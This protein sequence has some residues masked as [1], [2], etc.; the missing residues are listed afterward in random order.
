MAANRTIRNHPRMTPANF[1][2]SCSS[3]Y[4]GFFNR[5]SEIDWYSQILGKG[6]KPRIHVFTGPPNSG[7]T[8][9]LNKVLNIEQSA[10]SNSPVVAIDMREIPFTDAPSFLNAMEEFLAPWYNRVKEMATNFSVKVGNDLGNVTFVPGKLYEPDMSVPQK[11]KCIFSF[12]VKNMPK[13]SFWTGEQCPILFIDEANK[14]SMLTRTKEGRDALEQLLEFFVK[15]T[16]QDSLF[17]VVLASSDSF[18]HLWLANLIGE[19]RFTTHVIGHL[20]KEEARNYWEQHA[21]LEYKKI[22]DKFEGPEFEDV[23]AICGGSF[24]LMDMY[25]EQYDI[26][27]GSVLP[28]DF[29]FV[30]QQMRRL[31][32]YGLLES[33]TK[34]TKKDFFTV[35]TR[36]SENGFVVYDDLCDEMTKVVVDALIKT[37]LLH[38]R[39]THEFVYDLEYK[40]KE[41]ILTPTS[42]SS[43]AAMK[44]IVKNKKHLIE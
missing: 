30:K 18:Y 2:R 44:L 10:D 27:G 23:F 4:T 13:H 29:S 22:K 7:K 9:L 37:N 25:C 40:G 1:A 12:I 39:P 15:C 17:P 32:S 8:A 11:L 3:S 36:M 28:M 19:D 41:S 35:M 16:K 38:L 33:Q 26:N 6:R 14:M 21:L 43:A 34:W 5:R 31:M 24:M 20:S 42:P